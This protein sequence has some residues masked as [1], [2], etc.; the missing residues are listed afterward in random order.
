MKSGTLNFKGTLKF[1]EQK[2]S[3]YLLELSGVG[4]PSHTIKKLCQYTYDYIVLAVIKEYLVSMQRL[5]LQ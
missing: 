5:C 2:Y 1:H 4:F 3:L